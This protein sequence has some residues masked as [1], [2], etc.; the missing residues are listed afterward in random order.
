M[1]TTPIRLSPHYDNY[2]KAKISQGGYNDASEVIIAG[3]RLLE[4]IDLKSKDLKASIEEG[5]H[6]GIFTDF[7]AA[8]HLST[9]K[10]QRR[11]E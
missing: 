8:I 2:I 3:L 5:I 11:N 7:D 10:A 9:L 6:S 4:E 1:R